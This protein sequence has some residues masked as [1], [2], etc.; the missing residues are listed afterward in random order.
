MTGKFAGT[1]GKVSR[2]DMKDLKVFVDSV[3]RKRV[4]GQEVQVPIHPSNLMITNPVM[5]D[6][7][8]KE[9]V[10]RVKK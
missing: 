7:K 5:D 8:R 3:K 6:P 10:E 4:S 9:T 2:I 1:A